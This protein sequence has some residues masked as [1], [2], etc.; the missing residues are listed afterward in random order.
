MRRNYKILLIFAFS[1]VFV[2]F[3]FM[4]WPPKDAKV[5]ACE[6]IFVIQSVVAGGS[7][8]ATDF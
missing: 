4:P 8:L 2:L 7:F 5:S 6:I 1:W 3:Y